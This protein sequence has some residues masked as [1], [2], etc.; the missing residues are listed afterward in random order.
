MKDRIKNIL[1][2]PFISDGDVVLTPCFTC[3][4]LFE[5]GLKGDGRKKVGTVTYQVNILADKEPE[6][7]EFVKIL[8]ENLT[9]CEAINNISYSYE[10]SAKC[11]RCKLNLEKI[12]E[13]K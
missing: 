1:Q 4:L 3:Q 10:R 2:I 12:E 5:D 7:K 6:A 11:N 13:D 8:E 9:E